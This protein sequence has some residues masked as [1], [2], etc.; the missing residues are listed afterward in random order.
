MTHLQKELTNFHQIDFLILFLIV[1]VINVYNGF[2]L[3]LIHFVDIKYT[4]YLN[5]SFFYL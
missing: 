5:I 4:K 2:V 3:L 1:I